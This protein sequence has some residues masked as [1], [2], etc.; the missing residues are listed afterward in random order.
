MRI[1]LTRRGDYAVRAMLVLARDADGFMS[2]PELVAATAIPEAFLPQVMGDLVRAGLIENRRG[3]RGGYRLARPASAISL[4]DVVEAVEG[5]GRR[6]TCVLRGGPCRRDGPCDVHD[7]F[8]RAQEAVFGTL[9]S[10]SFA[11][12]PNRLG[13]AKPGGHEEARPDA[14]RA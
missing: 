12:L 6:R 13:S 11:D 1:E 5:D 4:L 14:G 8:F 10:V 3:R 9:A 7:A 2:G